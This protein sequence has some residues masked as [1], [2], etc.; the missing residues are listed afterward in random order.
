LFVARDYDAGVACLRRAATSSV[1]AVAS[2]AS[3][4]A[5]KFTRELG[6]IEESLSLFDAVAASTPAADLE[7]RTQDLRRKSAVRQRAAAALLGSTAEAA[8]KAW[9]RVLR[10]GVEAATRSIEALLERRGEQPELIA[11]RA[12]LDLL[13]GDR[14]RARERLAGA[15]ASSTIPS[16][17]SIASIASIAEQAALE[18]AEGAYD[19]VLALTAGSE[20]P[21]LLHLRGEALLC[22]QAYAEAATT[23][24]R[25][26]V[27]MPHSVAVGLS[28]AIAR[29]L[30]DPDSPAVEFE[31]RFE[32][33]LAAAPALLA[34]AAAL[35]GIMLWTDQG[36]V[37]SRVEGARILEQARALLTDDRDPVH[38]HYRQ[39]AGAPLRQVL[40]VGFDGPSHLARLHEHDQRWI[41]RI[42]STLLAKV[43]VD[44]QGPAAPRPTRR[45]QTPIHT[46]RSLAP[47]QIEQFLADG[48][49][50]IPR[51]FDPE[52]ARAWREDANRRIREQPHL[53][54]RG[55]DP[56]DQRKS[57]RDYSPTDPSTWTWPR[58]VLEGSVE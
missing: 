37:A 33:L 43:G 10:D 21:R 11:V 31:H 49:L 18:L 19:Q 13:R 4:L 50:R 16:I 41:D 54:V 3:K 17:P 15:R 39:R 48:F 27:A 30:E 5:V 26:R 53:W 45:A 51:A 46:P 2:F 29:Y 8:A 6:W 38:P 1:P 34:D 52:L 35:Q 56:D 55:Y 28:L 32:S 44:P 7:A 24:E 12:R 42:Q 20:A 36:P 22:G 57:L 47:E 25:A 9:A 58:L 23:L 14:A 40:P